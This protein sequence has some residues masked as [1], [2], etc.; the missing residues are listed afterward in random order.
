[1]TRRKWGGK[2]REVE[3]GVGSTQPAFLTTCVEMALSGTV[4]L[5]L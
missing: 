1:M 3:E 5:A 2:R 4:S